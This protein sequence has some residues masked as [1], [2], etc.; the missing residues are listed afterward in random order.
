MGKQDRIR[1]KKGGE[2]IV[3]WFAKLN[4]KVIKVIMVRL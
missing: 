2:N 4:A 1:I 3:L